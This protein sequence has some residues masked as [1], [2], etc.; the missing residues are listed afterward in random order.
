MPPRTIYVET[1]VI[2]YA[3]ARPVNHPQ[4][5]FR[6]QLTRKWLDRAMAS[7]DCELFVSQAVIEE[8]SRGDTEAVK[9]RLAAIRGIPI[10]GTTPLEIEFSRRLLEA[11]AVPPQAEV[12]ALHI[13]VAA[14]HDVEFLVTWNCT[15]IANAVTRR[16]IEKVC[17]KAGYRAPILCTPEELNFDEL[18]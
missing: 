11:R 16:T 12:D 9:E 6:F 4:V 2:G 13:A 8:I 17:R 1:S 10:L 7:A 5:S 15:H 14:L 3:T 18:V